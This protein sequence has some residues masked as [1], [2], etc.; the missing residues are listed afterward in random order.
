M[1]KV[2]YDIG[3]AKYKVNRLELFR[4]MEE[5]RG[6]LLS[7]APETPDNESAPGPDALQARDAA[8]LSDSFIEVMRLYNEY[9]RSESL[10]VLVKLKCLLEE[11]ST[12]YKSMA[13]AEQVLTIN[14][15]LPYDRRVPCPEPG[16]NSDY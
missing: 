5:A 14:S 13:L 1:E 8:T 4:M 15:C 16:E 7:S 9:A 6:N 2:I 3:N 12:R 11:V 10:D